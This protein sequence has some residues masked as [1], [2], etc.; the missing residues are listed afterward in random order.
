MIASD[1][2]LLFKIHARIITKYDLMTLMILKTS[3]G[4]V[5]EVEILRQNYENQ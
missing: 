5:R 1:F 3:F 2:R 4:P